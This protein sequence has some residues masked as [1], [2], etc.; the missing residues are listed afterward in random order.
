MF[1][2]KV[3]NIQIRKFFI[4]DHKVR[5][6]CLSIVLVPRLVQSNRIVNSCNIGGFVD[7][8]LNS[9]SILLLL[10]L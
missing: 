6:K 5:L 3:M 7:T 4:F 1:S 8:P 9:S 10:F 2:L